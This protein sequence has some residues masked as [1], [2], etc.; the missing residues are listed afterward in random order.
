MGGKKDFSVFSITISLKS[1]PFFRFLSAYFS[2]CLA[3]GR[4]EKRSHFG[5]FIGVIIISEEEKK[6]IRTVWGEQ[7]WILQNL[8]ELKSFLFTVYEDLLCTNRKYN[9]QKGDFFQIDFPRVLMS[10]FLLIFAPRSQQSLSAIISKRARKKLPDP[11]THTHTPSLPFRLWNDISYF[12]PFFPVEGKRPI[13]DLRFISHKKSPAGIYGSQVF[14]FFG[15]AKGKTKRNSD[16]F[17]VF[18]GFLEGK[19]WFY[20]E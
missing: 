19:S 5:L 4:G 14:S 2:A 20:R 1:F 7:E 9:F 17:S 8:K 13:S 3:L 10:F 12:F 16:S 18:P 11:H 6:K 15:E